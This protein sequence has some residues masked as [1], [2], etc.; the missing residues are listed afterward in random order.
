MAVTRMAVLHK[1]GTIE[2]GAFTAPFWFRAAESGVQV[3][4]GL[5]VVQKRT[6]E[7]PKAAPNFLAAFFL[8][9]Y[10]RAQIPCVHRVYAPQ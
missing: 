7:G 5:S 4:I 6:R 3:L 9:S 2:E 10:S 8:R 1:K